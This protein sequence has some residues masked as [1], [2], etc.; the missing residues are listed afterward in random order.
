MNRTQIYFTKK[1]HDLLIQEAE[2][3]GLSM[4][5]VIR[6]IIDKHFEDKEYRPCRRQLPRL[7]NVA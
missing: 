3:K 5:D 6:R 7:E 4:S 2:K 1:E